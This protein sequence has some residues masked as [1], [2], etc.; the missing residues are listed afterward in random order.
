[1]NSA[2][3]PILVNKQSH[4]IEPI[5]TFNIVINVMYASIKFENYFVSTFMSSKR[6]W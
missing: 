2:N 4:H 3:S 5:W 6:I 1:M